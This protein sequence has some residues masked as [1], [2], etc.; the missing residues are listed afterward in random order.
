[1]IALWCFMSFSGIASWENILNNEFIVNES[2]ST[3]KYDYVVFWY[4]KITYIRIFGVHFWYRLYF[5]I[6]SYPVWKSLLVIESECKLFKAL[7]YELYARTKEHIVILLKNRQKWLQKA[8][9]QIVVKCLL[10]VTQLMPHSHV[11]I[12]FSDYTISVIEKNS[13]TVLHKNCLAASN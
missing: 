8:L 5:W 4:R 3:D 7:T 11:H 10:Y 2:F 6:A 9:K 13:N 12:L 1:M